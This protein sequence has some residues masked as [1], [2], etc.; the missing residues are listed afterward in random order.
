MELK[1]VVVSLFIVLLFLITGCSEDG[2][3]ATDSSLQTEITKLQTENSKLKKELSEI[4]TNEEQ[5]HP[6]EKA[7]FTQEVKSFSANEA[8]EFGDGEKKLAEMKV[9]QVTTKQSAFPKR[10]IELENYDTKQ[11]LAVKIEYSNINMDTPFLPYAQ[12]FQ[13]Y[14]KKGERLEA[15]NQQRGQNEVPKGKSGTTQIF[16]KLPV[17]G[18]K[19]DNVEIDF[20]SGEQRVATFDLNVSH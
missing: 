1:K 8:I 11:M 19:F 10:M 15:I 13:A 16:W 3:T 6:S 14:S 5:T 4:R 7:R 20:V 2:S 17:D 18:E 12:S 9:V